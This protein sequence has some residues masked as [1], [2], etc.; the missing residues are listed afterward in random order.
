[1]QGHARRAPPAAQALTSM[2]RAGDTALH[3]AVRLET[4]ALRQAVLG[5]L[6]SPPRKKKPNVAVA[7]NDGLTPLM[8][9]IRAGHG[10]ACDNLLRRRQNLNLADSEGCTAL[11][12]AG[13]RG[14]P[15][16]VLLCGCCAVR[17]LAQRLV[18]QARR[19]CL[20]HHRRPFPRHSAG[21]SPPAP[22]ALHFVLLA[23][24][25]CIHVPA[26]TCAC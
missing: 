20:P 24:A 11:H 23:A 9:A 5:V 16:R 12:C 19:S 25:A 26:C 2:R 21:P 14:A 13:A 8:L 6:L 7:N 1:M 3:H 10:D 4:Q 15:S 17:V 22:G 18:K